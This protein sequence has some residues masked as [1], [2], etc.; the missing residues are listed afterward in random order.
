MAATVDV[1]CLMHYCGHSYSDSHMTTAFALFADYKPRL[2]H[3][4]FI[5]LS[6]S[7]QPE[8]K[9]DSAWDQEEDLIVLPRHSVSLQPG[10]H[11]GSD[12]HWIYQKVKPAADFHD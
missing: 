7:E 3:Q 2:L 6:D 5:G 9:R 10:R 1:G 8:A 12:T 11:S 4:P